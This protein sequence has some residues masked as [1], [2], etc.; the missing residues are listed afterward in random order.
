MCEL[1]IYSQAENNFELFLNKIKVGIAYVIM[2]MWIFFIV[3]YIPTYTLDNI[4]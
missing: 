2:I 3:S 1:D 4:N